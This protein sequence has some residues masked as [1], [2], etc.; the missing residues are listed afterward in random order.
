MKNLPIKK[1]IFTLLGLCLPLSI[2][3]SNYLFAVAILVLLFNSSKKEKTDWLLLLILLIPVLIPIVSILFHKEQFSFTALE[4]KIPFIVVALVIG[5]L[6]LNNELLSKFKNGIVWGTLLGATLSLFESSIFVNYLQSS[7]FF[8]F[9]Y[10]PLFTVISLIYLWFTDIKINIYIKIILSTVFIG[11]LF[12]FNNFFFLTFGLLIVF[13]AIIVKGSSLQSKVAITLLV[14]LS[15]LLLYKGVTIQQIIH[16]NTAEK[17]LNP[18]DKMAQWQCVLEVMKDNEL[19]GVG[20]IQRKNL[21][22]NCYHEHGMFKAEKMALN[23]HNEYLDFFLILGYIG[24]LGLLIY[25][26]KLMFAAYDN[27]QVAHL[28]VIILITLFAIT[29]NVFWRQKGVMIITI[30]TLMVFSSKKTTELSDVE[31][32]SNE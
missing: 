12:L 20:Y 25:F 30:T 29:E 6:K 14:L 17:T 15:S 21:L 26:F 19:F 1:N 32:L 13:A 27:K 8:D 18:V 11:L 7:L 23:A 5:F 16:Q 10:I 3:F 2:Y 9:T 28:L 4:V 24:V 31:S 22:L